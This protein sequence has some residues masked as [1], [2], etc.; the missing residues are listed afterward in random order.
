MTSNTLTAQEEK[1]ETYNNT[2][3]THQTATTST[4][5][6]RED[7]Q[8]FSRNK[9]KS[10]TNAD[11]VELLA[12][13]PLPIVHCSAGIGR[14]GAA[15]AIMN[16]IGQMRYK[17][18]KA[19][20]DSVKVDILR[21]VCN[22]RL[23]RGG[24]VQNSEQY[25]LIHKTLCIY[26]ERLFSNASHSSEWDERDAL[27]KIFDVQYV[28]KRMTSPFRKH[29]LFQLPLFGSSSQKKLE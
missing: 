25:E 4:L 10:L 18:C 19:D 11:I 28:M 12:S 8:V 14:T 16:G 5:T 27:T 7:K 26:Q 13:K 1:V 21:I 24:M 17:F 6:Y 2:T 29:N 22:L 3:I 9:S 23:S 15:I 20:S